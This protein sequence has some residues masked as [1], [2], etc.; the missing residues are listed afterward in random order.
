[1]SGFPALRELVERAFR[2]RADGIKA[3]IALAAL[4]LVAAQAPVATDRERIRDAVEELLQRPQAHRLR[5]LEAAALVSSGTVP[6]PQ[7][8]A[9]ELSDLDGGQTPAEQLAAPGR[10]AA[11]LPGEADRGTLVRPPV[12]TG[13]RREAGR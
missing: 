1:R 5:L 2:R 12:V 13:Y 4:E 9:A 6:M 7:V 11:A 3:S 8:R 10:D